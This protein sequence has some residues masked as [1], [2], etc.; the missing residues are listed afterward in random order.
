MPGRI[1]PWHFFALHQIGPHWCLHLSLTFID[2]YNAMTRLI[3]S[4]PLQRVINLGH[5]KRFGKR[6][7]RRFDLVIQGDFY[8][9]QYGGRAS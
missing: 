6:F 3:A 1:A 4:E 7:G 2:Q 5:G 8:H 9:G